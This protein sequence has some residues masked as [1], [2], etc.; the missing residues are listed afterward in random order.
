MCQKDQ[1]RSSRNQNLSLK[2]LNLLTIPAPQIHWNFLWTISNLS[3][4]KV[5]K[6]RLSFSNL[7]NPIPKAAQNSHKMCP[8]GLLNPLSSNNQKLSLRLLNFPT[9]PNP[10]TGEH[11]HRCR[12]QMPSSICPAVWCE[13]LE[14][15]EVENW[16]W[17]NPGLGN[18][19]C[20]C[21]SATC[22]MHIGRLVSLLSL[23]P[24]GGRDFVS[25]HLPLGVW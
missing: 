13:R 2:L 14:V 1:P 10:K 15:E 4:P 17:G 24:H 16:Q 21:D 22:R 7:P 12:W 18:P 5:L 8:N 25:Q 19:E 6:L 23:S 20:G 9:T 3:N 11:L